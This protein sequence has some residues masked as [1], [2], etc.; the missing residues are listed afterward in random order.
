[1]GSAARSLGLAGE[2]GDGRFAALLEGAGLRRAPSE[3]AVAGFDL[4]FRAPKSVSVLWA[5]APAGVAA[6]LRTGHD[7]AVGEALR[8]LEREAC[9]A[10]RGAGGVV[11]V[12][13]GG[14]VAADSWRRRSCIVRR[15]PAIRCSTRMSWSGT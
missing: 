13:G 9:R 7:A 14:F 1:M 15:A 11:Q 8:Y 4:T 10:R 3:G 2:V 5:V 6:E 12:R